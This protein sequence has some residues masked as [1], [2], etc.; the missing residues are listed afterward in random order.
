MKQANRNRWKKYISRL[1]TIICLGVFSYAAFNLVLIFNDYYQNRK[2]LN[3][4]Q[5]TF[6]QAKKDMGDSQS[7]T[8]RPGFQAL[9]EQNPD[10]V[11]WIT[12][13]GTQVDYPILQAPNNET[14][15]TRNYYGKESRAGSIFLD[16]RNDVDTANDQNTVIYGHRMKDGSMFQQLTKFLDKDFFESHKAFQFDTLYDSYEAEIFAVYNTLTDF[17]YIQTNFS[18]DEQ[19]EAFLAKVQK[20]SLYKTDVELNPDDAIITLSTCEYTLDQD[21]GRL[22]VQA[23]LVKK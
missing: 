16:Y 15:L 13:E 5:D 1:I 23:K 8:I 11:G 20:K 21:N 2:M 12:I 9:L 4:L 3:E 6:Y 7:H 22:V 10:V 19:Y 14:Y 17:D 18:T